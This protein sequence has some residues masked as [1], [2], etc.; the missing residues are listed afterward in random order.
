MPYDTV[1]V[2]SPHTGPE[3]TLFQKAK[4]VNID[5]YNSYPELAAYPPRAPEPH[6]WVHRREPQLRKP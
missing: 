1:R 6:M 2:H 3:Q 4:M 5:A